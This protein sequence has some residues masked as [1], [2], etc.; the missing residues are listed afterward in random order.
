MLFRLLGP[1]DVTDGD[2]PIRIGAGRRRSVLVM[3]LLHRNAVLPSEQLLDA[4]WG[5]EP[6][7]GREGAAERR[8]TA[9]ASAR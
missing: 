2:H 1:L 4:V 7:D 6:A 5:E 8:G 9:A 3:L